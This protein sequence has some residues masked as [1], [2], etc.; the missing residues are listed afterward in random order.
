MENKY[1]IL[2]DLE[3]MAN[4]EGRTISEEG[5]ELVKVIADMVDAAHN[6][7]YDQGFAAGWEVGFVA[8]KTEIKEE[9]AK[10]GRAEME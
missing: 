7:G 5:V 4:A 8:G 2:K 9:Y 3:A 1:E 6:A 10:T